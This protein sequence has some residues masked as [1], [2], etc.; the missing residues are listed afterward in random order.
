MSDEKFEI[1][2]EAVSARMDQV[3]KE[4]TEVAIE[5]KMVA[6]AYRIAAA[7]LD[8]CSASVGNAVVIVN[9]KREE[10]FVQSIIS[11]LQKSIAN[12]S[13]GLRDQSTKLG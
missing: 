1:W 12:M 8:E 2:S 4:F 3:L 7:V 6:A 5:P 9:G 13:A 10:E 11:Q